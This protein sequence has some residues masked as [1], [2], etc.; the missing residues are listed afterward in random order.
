MSL[1]ELLSLRDRIAIVTGASRGLGKAFA[2]ALAEAG[3]HLAIVSRHLDELQDTAAAV[4]NCKRDVLTLQADITREDQVREMVRQTVGR[5]GGIDILVN[6]A[7]T[8]R[9]NLPP[10]QTTLE[11]WSFV[12]DTNVNGA[13]LCAREVGKVMI[14]QKRGKIINMASISGMIIN[15][16]FHGGSY[17]VSKSAVVA[18]TKALAVEWAKYNVN[19]IAL[20]PGYYGTTPNKKWFEANPEIYKQVIDMIPLKRL[21]TIE[22]LAALVTVLASEVSNYITG[23]TVVIDGGYTLW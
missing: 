12:I 8:E 1:A 23:S 9:Q 22:E 7:A 13:F 5:F 16:Y 20:A 19:V 17:D 3:A 2:T 6:N 15:K 18:L 10:E 21:G 4:K 11:N 14:S